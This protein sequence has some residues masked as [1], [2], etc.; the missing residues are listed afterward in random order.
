MDLWVFNSMPC[1]M[2]TICQV[3]QLIQLCLLNP[4]SCGCLCSSDIPLLLF[5]HLLGGTQDASSAF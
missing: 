2:I 4:P 3:M 5:E 1:D